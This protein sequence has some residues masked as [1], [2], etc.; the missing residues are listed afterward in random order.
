MAKSKPSSNNRHSRSNKSV[1]NGTRAHAP[2]RPAPPPDPTT[3]LSQA[4]DALQT[5]QPELAL[6]IATKA[7]ALLSSNET[8]ISTSTS[9][10]ST[11]SSRGESPYPITALPALSLLGAIHLELGSPDEARNAFLEAVELDPAGTT[12]TDSEGGAA[13]RFL[14][15]AQ[16]CEEGGDESL[17]WFERGIGVL[18]RE[19]QALADGKPLPKSSQRNGMD[20]REDRLGT[21]SVEDLLE[22]KRRKVAEALC[23]MAEVWM[24]DLSYAALFHLFYQVIPMC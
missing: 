18:E 13:E 6:P 9:P 15:L 5:G 20:R 21:V 12:P 24:T 8:P 14:W 10:P 23:G 11:S 2:K 1:L 22:E 7:L 3:L 17:R 19:I 4:A 16:L